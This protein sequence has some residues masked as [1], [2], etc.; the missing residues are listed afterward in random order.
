MS[1]GCENNCKNF[2]FH[3][4]LEFDSELMWFKAQFIVDTSGIFNE[5]AAGLFLFSIGKNFYIHYMFLVKLQSQ[6]QA[7]T[8]GMN[9]TERNFT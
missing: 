1:K 9:K 8:L 2:H 6:A 3:Y 4:V 7:L 5:N